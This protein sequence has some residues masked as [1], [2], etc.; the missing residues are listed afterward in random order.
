MCTILYVPATCICKTACITR[1]VKDFRWPV[2]FPVSGVLCRSLVGAR[3]AFS[4][5]RKLL[6]GWVSAD[7]DCNDFALSRRVLRPGAWL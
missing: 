7:E 1:K 2:P 4:R 6:P 3:F 5:R